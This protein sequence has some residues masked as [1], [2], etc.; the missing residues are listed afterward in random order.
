MELLLSSGHR[1]AQPVSW[2]I[3]FYYAIGLIRLSRI[4][5]SLLKID[6]ASSLPKLEE[7]V[8]RR[9]WK[10]ELIAAGLCILIIGSTPVIADLLPINRFPEISESSLITAVNNKEN[11]LFSGK[12]G[13]IEEFINAVEE[14]NL[15]IVYGRILSPIF[16]NNEMF[17]LFYGK[18]NFG[19]KGTY[20]A[21]NVLGPAPSRFTRMFFYPQGDLIEIKNGSEAVIFF[22]KE[23]NEKKAIGVGII[24]PAFSSK[25]SSYENISQIPIIIFLPFKRLFEVYRYSR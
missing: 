4:L 12:N 19:G 17:L 10:T 9:G 13:H 11:L 6:I 18:E 20:L 23:K 1:Y 21:F 3:F 15:T 2:I 7:T 25:I 14:N 16:A 22:N 24:D 5:F 8:L